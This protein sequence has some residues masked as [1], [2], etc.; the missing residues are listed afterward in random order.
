MKEY[1]RL[2]DGSLELQDIPSEKR[3][4]AIKDF[5]ELLG[6]LREYDVNIRKEEGFDSRDYSY[7]RFAELFY[8]SWPQARE[9][10]PFRG[11]SQSVFQMIAPALMQYPK[12]GREIPADEWE[13]L[14]G[15]KCDF[16]LDICPQGKP[17]YCT[18]KAGWHR[19]RIGYYIVRQ[20]DYD[21]KDDDDSFL[22]NKKFSDGMLEAE[23]AGFRKSPGDHS[24]LDALKGEKLGVRFHKGVMG[25]HS[26]RTIAADIEEFGTRICEA[27]FYRHEEELSKAEQRACGSRRKIFSMK[28]REGKR[29]YISLDFAHGMLEYI[30]PLGDHIGEYR[31]T[32]DENFRAETDH[33]FKS[34]YHRKLS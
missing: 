22:P 14:G 12:I 7:G 25:H 32:G 19:D 4:G 20:E 27:N 8:K 29:Q 2:L 30:S 18:Q 15:F 17:S 5:L 23:I 6:C 16:G 33:G 34:G 26:G 10:E 21:W 13:Q 28:N 24:A 9:L 1:A 31:L 11:V 3:D